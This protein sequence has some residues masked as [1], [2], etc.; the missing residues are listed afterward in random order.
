MDA[1]K[2]VEPWSGFKEI[3][4]IA[5]TK[6]N[7]TYLVDGEVYKTY[8]LKEG[9]TIT[10]EPAPSKENC[11]FSGWSEIPETMPA[12]NVEITGSFSSL[13]NYDE[14]KIGSSGINSFSSSYDLDFTN[15]EGLKAYIASG[16]N[17]DTKVIWLM[18]VYQVPANTGLLVKGTSG[19]TYHVPHQTTHSYYSN[20]LRANTG[21]EITL[22]ETDGDMTNYYLKSGKLLS[23]NESATIGKKVIFKSRQKC[24]H[25]PAPLGMSLAM[26]MA[27]RPC[28]KILSSPSKRTKSTTIFK[29]SV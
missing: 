9:E 8:Q 25:E 23:V 13:S 22:S 6:Y 7:L 21:E 14:I 17:D 12:Y 27:Q 2:A 3:V 29:A 15:V 5:E 26:M 1:Y 19:G 24:L 16:Y 4:S 18:R 10:P 11:V 28:L 20:M